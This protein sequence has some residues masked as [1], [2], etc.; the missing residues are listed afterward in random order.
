MK[1]SGKKLSLP[2]YDD[3]FSTEESRV[4]DAREKVVQI[5]L[6]ELHPFAE[7]PF[8]VF[9][10]EKMQETV[11]SIAENG[12]LV[13]AIA[14]PRPEGGYELI[15]GHRRKHGCEL[16]G[17]ETMPVIVRDLTDD[18]AILMMVDS[19]IQRETLLPSERAFA[20]KMR[21]DAMKRTHG[22]PS[23]RN[24][25]QFETQKRTDQLMAEQTGESRAT[26]QRYIRL[27]QLLPELL[28]MVDNRKLGMNPAVEISFL[29]KE[30][31]ADLL[32][33][34]ES[35]QAM[36]T[37]AQ[38]QRMK[39]F[40]YAKRL[41][42]DVMREILGEARGAD[43]S[44][45]VIA[46]NDLREYYPSHF[47]DQMIHDEEDEDDN[48]TDLH[49]NISPATNAEFSRML[50]LTDN[51]ISREHMSHLAANTGK[52]KHAALMHEQSEKLWHEAFRSM[53]KYVAMSHDDTISHIMQE[54]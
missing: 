11:D 19:N 44:T 17:L 39:K 34:I 35:E 10:D 1:S 41:T 9:D 32:D 27:T 45:G 54:L 40:S 47:T 2:A 48:L 38:A 5:P 3:I 22:R 33:A 15:S 23:L 24:V 52:P 13:P 36:P 51:A 31:Q 30:E 28:D 29:T 7:H 50:D 43:R 6:S 49:P 4:D 18:Q 37:L 12:V 25:S 8:R 53:C 21:L 14:R 16:L 20:Y 26:I 42:V 46:Y